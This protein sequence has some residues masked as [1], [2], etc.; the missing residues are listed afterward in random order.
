MNWTTDEIHYLEEHAGDGAKEIAS[1]LGRTE[2]SV[3]KQ[4][5]RY[6]IS[7][8]RRWLCPRC[9]MVTFRP[10]SAR[11]GFCSNCTKELRRERIADEV[12][13]ME[14]EARRQQKED[15]ERQR[16]YSRKNRAKK[17]LEEMSQG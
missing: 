15:R 10:L 7:L 16:L 14:E 3:R 5:A 1:A 2:A 4:A 11:T 17:K 8:R 9:G 12:R 13:D 6:G